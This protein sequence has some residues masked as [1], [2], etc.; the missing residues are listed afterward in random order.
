MAAWLSLLLALVPVCPKVSFL[1]YQ[2]ALGA[3]PSPQGPKYV[4]AAVWA[5]KWFPI[6]LLLG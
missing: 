3:T 1:P 4:C 5:T 6:I 2:V